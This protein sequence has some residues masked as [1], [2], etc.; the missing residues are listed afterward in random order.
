[1]RSLK[2]LKCQDEMGHFYKF[3][4]GRMEESERGG[5]WQ[6]GG[7]LSTGESVE[8]RKSLLAVLVSDKF[9]HVC[10]NCERVI[11]PLKN[12]FKV[13]SYILL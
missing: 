6:P 2:V 12:F 1:M 9:I 4:V 13:S 11:K 5:I 3:V 7:F 8:N 10:L